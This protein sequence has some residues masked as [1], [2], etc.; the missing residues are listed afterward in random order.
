MAWQTQAL[1]LSVATFAATLALGWGEYRG[2]RALVYAAKPLATLLILALAC[3]APAGADPRV[4]RWIFLGLV[5][6][7]AGDVLLMLPSDRFA[8]GLAS[9][10]VAH[11]CYIAAFTRRGGLPAG[12][13]RAR[14]AARRRGPRLPQA[15]ARARRAAHPGAPLHRHDRGDGLAGARALRGRAGRRAAARRRRRAA[16]RGIRFDAR[17]RALPRARF[18]AHRPWCMP[19]I[20]PRSG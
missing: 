18:A 3:L 20:S 7:L 14:A 8:A 17:A 6:S 9:F 12:A 19:A 2:P 13:A 4:A 16:V 10:L 5:C 15:R 11:L 1:T